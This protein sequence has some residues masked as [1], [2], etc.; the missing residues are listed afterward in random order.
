MVQRFLLDRGVWVIYLGLGCLA[1]RPGRVV[2]IPEAAT[3]A[4]AAA[5]TAWVRNTVPRESSFRRFK[6]TFRDERAT[7]GGRGTV[8]I[9]P[10]DSA[11]LDVAGPL[12]ADPA[13]AF[14]IGDSARWTEPEDAAKDLVPNYQLMWAMFGV[15]R[16]PDP[17][18]TVQAFVL[19]DASLWR[20]VA[21]TDTVEYAEFVGEKP[22]LVAVVRRAGRLVGQAETHFAPDGGL[23]RARLLT[24]GTRLD[25]E[26]YADSIPATF[27]PSTWRPGG[28]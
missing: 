10:P 24:P 23:A 16:E 20:Y 1:C 27:P 21:G 11:R 17:G 15:A 4:D 19:E 28:R 25:L 26:F 18:A 14:V 9:A 22:R 8:R 2:V 6:W 12:G 13:A 7:A 5:V 3:P